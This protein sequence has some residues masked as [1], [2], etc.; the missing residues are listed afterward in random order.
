[1][2]ILRFEANTPVQ[3]ALKFDGGRDV[4]GRYGPQV[5]YT[6]TDY[7]LTDGRLMYLEP[8]AACRINE[9]KITAGEPFS[10]CK[11]ESRNA[12][13]SSRR[14]SRTAGWRFESYEAFTLTNFFAFAWPPEQ[15][16]PC[17]PVPSA[18]RVSWTQR[19]SY[20]RSFHRVFHPWR[21]A[22]GNIREPLAEAF[23]VPS[24]HLTAA[25]RKLADL[26]LILQGVL[27]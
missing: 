25:L 27:D 12:Q 9:L 26:L 18:V 24:S 2:N 4:D 7:T 13:P 1:M 11:R 8:T 6:L 23:V 20:H 15:P 3:L 10:T 17:A 21:L 16:Q 19:P 22:F 14:G 5:L